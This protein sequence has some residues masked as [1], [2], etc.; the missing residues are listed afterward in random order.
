MPWAL[1][2]RIDSK[3]K[4]G[5]GN[6]TGE[7]FWTSFSSVRTST[8]TIRGMLCVKFMDED[9]HQIIS[10][11]IISVNYQELIKTK[12][13]KKVLLREHK[14]HTARQARGYPRYPPPARPGRGGTLGA[15]PTSRPGRGGYLGYPSTIQTWP[16]Y[17]PP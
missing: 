9:Y 10:D 3:R 17:P 16:R 6:G 1:D 11:K 12:R 2:R 4:E 13:N 15:P 14:R 5:E 8:A 7:A